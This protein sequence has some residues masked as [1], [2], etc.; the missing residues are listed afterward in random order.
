[1]NMPCL[2]PKH[3][4]R[5]ITHLHTPLGVRSV[6]DSVSFCTRCGSCQQACPLYRQTRQENF[7]PRGLNQ[8]VRLF[9]EGKLTLA[10]H[11]ADVKAQFA[12]CLLCGQCTAQCAG[13]VPTAEHVL[14]MRRALGLRVLP[15]SL[16]RFLRLRETN[17]RRFAVWMYAGLWARRIGLLFLLRP[18]LPVWLRRL[19]EMLPSKLPLRHLDFLQQ[20]TYTSR[21]GTIYMPSWETQW[22]CPQ[23]G[24]AVLALLQKKHR[25]RIWENTATGLFSFLYGDVRESRKQLRKLIRRHRSAQC[26][27][28]V[29]DD[30]DEYQFLRNAP[31]LFEGFAGWKSWAEN[32]AR[33]TRFITDF[34]PLS[35]LKARRSEGPVRLLG[36]CY[37]GPAADVLEKSCKILTTLFKQNFVEYED[38]LFGWPPVLAGLAGT[39][40]AIRTEGEIVKNIARTQTKTVVVLS[41]L[42]ALAVNA[43]LARYYPA[44]KAVPIAQVVSR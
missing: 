15:G 25:V 12:A 26:P 28:I 8:L 21:I 6:Y 2:D 33:S 16:Q 43:T 4:K 1:M 40:F 34:I 23:Q 41:G 29:V 19:D 32:L 38:P 22:L 10:K 36:G 14:E 39:S 5:H 24:K 11:G 37:R 3:P 20:T 9:M 30:I 44:A 31:Q 42:T 7:S 35:S 18:V 13:R 27:V 17:P